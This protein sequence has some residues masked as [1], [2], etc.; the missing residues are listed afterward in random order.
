M[1]MSTSWS[2]FF[3]FALLA[4]A[5]RAEIIDRIAITIGDHVITEQQIVHEIRV[6]A[7]LNRETPDISTASRHAGAER[8]I[9]QQLI[10]RE[11]ESTHYPEPEKSEAAPL[12][13]QVIALYG[14]ESPYAA[15]LTSN[16][17]TRGDIL[18]ELWWQ[19][20]TL[21][22]IDFR[23]KPAIHIPEA[24][25][26]AYYERQVDKWKAQGQKDIPSLEQSHDSFEE[27]LA[28]QRVD[29]ALDSW[30]DEAR[31]HANVKYREDA[32]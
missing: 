3:L 13:K 20:T 27:I 18:D 2:R 32:F 1:R 11:M 8:L 10:R 14:G 4:F 31:K 12:E 26:A 22:F 21:R 25:I 19:L 15:A 24:D 7:F 28:G 16:N 23:F 30:L 5:L 9:K 6:A 29:Q 17:L